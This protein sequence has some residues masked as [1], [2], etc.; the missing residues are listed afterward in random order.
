MLRDVAG[1]G[2]A[3]LWF[4]GGNKDCWGKRPALRLHLNRPTLRSRR[5]YQHAHGFSS[6]NDAH[7]VDFANN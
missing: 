6:G 5:A 4:A 3:V 2:R 7:T 1:G